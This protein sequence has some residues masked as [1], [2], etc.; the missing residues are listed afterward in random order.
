MEIKAEGRGRK[1]LSSVFRNI[2]T[3]PFS[4][5]NY[6]KL[7]YS[8]RYLR[9]VAKISLLLVQNVRHLFRGNTHLLNQQ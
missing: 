1:S 7:C 9:L 8:D 2:T 3:L 4:M 5:A 6:G